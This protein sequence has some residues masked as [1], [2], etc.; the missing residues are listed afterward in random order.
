MSALAPIAIVGRGCV[1]PGALS[2]EE[3]WEGVVGGVDLT[4][5]VPEARWGVDVD[6]VLRSPGQ[7][8]TDGTWSDRGGYVTGFDEV[9]D[10]TGFG[11]D[12]A[13]I[14][15]LDPV[16]RWTLHTARAALRDAGYGEADAR[17]TGAVFGNLSYPTL[18]MAAHAS[19]VHLARSG[20]TPP[21]VDGA[22]GVRVDPRNRFMSG[23]PA[24]LLERALG[25]GVGAT[26][27]DAACAS[28][29]YAIE[30]AC[31]RLRSGEADLM[32]AGAV[33]AADDLFLHVGFTALRALS[34]TGRSRPFHP[35]ADGLVPA[36]GCGFVALRRLDDAVRDGDEIHGVVRGVGLSND[37][38]GRGMLA[39]SS[40]GQVRAIRSAL[41][42]SGLDP[43]D[44]SLLECHATGTTV[45]DATEVAS[46]A[47]AYGDVADLPIGSLKSN[48]GHLI[49]VA[50]VAAVIK[51]IEAMRHEVRPP[52]LHVGARPSTL[53]GS[54]F[55]VLAAAEAW[56]R[57]ESPDGV[58]RAGISAFGF[59]GNN[60]HLLLEEPPT[61]ARRPRRQGRG[62]PSPD[63]TD[64]AAASP[65][66]VGS[67]DDDGHE[68][69]AGAGRGAGPIAIV[70]IGV[71]AA[72]AVGLD[73]LRDALLAD[74]PRLDADGTGRIA[75]LELRL[76]AQRSPPNDLR[77]ALGQHLAVLQAA[78]EAVE[79]VELPAA[80]TGVVVGIGTDPV[81]T[82]FGTRW[83]LPTEVDGRSPTA[84]ERDAVAPALTAPGVLGAMPNLVANR[85]DSQYD[86]GG[87]SF[88]VSSEE[89]SGLDAL[90]IAV[91]ALRRGDLDAALVGAVDL[92]CDEVHL[93]AARDVLGDRGSA[94]P[95]GD[96][97]VVV[98]LKRL[99]DAERDGDVVHAVVT[100][101]TC[102]TPDG[103]GREPGEDVHLDPCDP[104]SSLGHLFGHAHA[105]AGLLHVAAAATMLRHRVGRGD[106]ALIARRPRAAR[107][108]D[109]EAGPRT[110][111]ITTTAMEGGVART[112][113]LA[114]AARHPAPGRAPT[115]G[116]HV[117]S[118][119]DVDEVLGALA[120]GRE[121]D[122]GPARL[123]IVAS[124]SDE[125]AE[126]ARRAESH[127]RDGA[128]AGIGVH[129]A[130]T[131]IEGELGFVFT[132]AGAAVGSMGVD[133]LRA[134]PE[135]V[136]PI[137]A[138]STI[139]AHGGWFV[140][141][142]ADHQPTA[143]EYLWGTAL[144]SQAHAR[145]SI[146]LLGLRPDA[147]LGSSSGESNSLYAMG[148]WSDLDAMIDEIERGGMLTHEIAGDF[149]AV[150]RAWGVED[151]DWQVWSVAAPVDEVRALV[152]GHERVHLMII[153]TEREVVIGGDAAGC[154]HVVDDVGRHRCRRVGYELACHVPEVAAAFHDEWRR[155]HDRPV[156]P[157]DGV[158]F[159]SNGV[160]GAYDVS[161]E[162]CADAITRQAETTVD[163][164][165]T[166]R[167]AY[168]DG[169]RVFVEHGPGGA[170]THHV[171][172]VLADEVAAGEVLAV[173]LDRRGAG[174][175][176]LLDTC[177][178]LAAAGVEVDHRALVDRIGRREPS[179]V[180]PDG[181]VLRIP[182]HPRPVVVP[183][184]PGPATVD[185]GSRAPGPT[186]P[187]A[188]RLPSVL[189]PLEDHLV[190]ATLE[191][192][193]P[194]A[195]SPAPPRVATPLATPSVHGERPDVGANAG[196]SAAAVAGPTDGP[197]TGRTVADLV[198]AQLDALDR[199]HRGYLAQQSELHER[200]LATRAA[201]LAT[202]EGSSA[203]THLPAAAPTTTATTAPARATVAPAADPAVATATPGAVQAPAVTSTGV[204]PGPLPGRTPTTAAAAGTPDPGPPTGGASAAGQ[205]PFRPPWDHAQLEIH[206]S[207]R[208]SE[209]FGPMFEPQD[210]HVVQCRMPRPPLL[211]ADRVTGIDAEPGVLGTGT[212]WT[213]TDVPADAWYLHAGRMPT[214]F[215]IEAGQ[216]DLML[217]SWM[218][219]DLL[220]RGRRA[221]RLLGCTLTYHGDLPRPGET[222]EYEIRIT[223][224][225][226]HGEVRLFFFEYDCTVAGVRRLTVRDGQAGFFTRAELEDA[227]GTVW[228]PEAGRAALRD[229][230]RVD[231][232]AVRCAKTR[233]DA[234]E[235][236]AFSEG[237]V[238]D[239]FGPGFE[240]AATHTRTPGIQSGALLFVDEVTDL[241]PTGGPWGRGFMRCE[242]AIAADAW[243]FEGH[244]KDDPCMPGNFMVESCVQ[245]MSFYLAAL[246]HTLGRDGWR[247]RP[248]PEQPF[249]LKCRGEI[250]PR[251]ERVAY[252]LHV[253]EVHDGP[254][255]R[256]VCDVLG[257]VDGSP[258]FHA[259]RL[260]IELV[261]GWPLE[262]VPVASASAPVTARPSLRDADGFAF[263]ER[264]MLACAWGRPTDAFGGL[265][266]DVDE[267]RRI[268]RLPGP[269]YH[270]VSRAVELDGET[271]EPRIGTRAVCEYDVPTDAWYFDD[272]S[273]G[274]EATMPFAVLLEVA[275]Q[276]C[277]WLASLVGSIVGVEGD[278]L[279][280]NL[281]GTATV[282][283]TVT[284]TAGRIATTV[285]L[286]RSSR[287]GG[288]IVE[289]FDVEC[290]VGDRVVFTTGTVFGFFPTSA[291]VDQAGLAVGDADRAA[292]RLDACDEVIDLADRP[293]RYF[294]GSAR[295]TS[296]PLLMLDRI[297]HRRGAGEAG[298]G[299]V[300]GERDVDGSDWSF[301][302]HFF[303]DPVQPGS[304]GMEALL[305]LLRCH[306]L[307]SVAADDLAGAVFEPIL[308]AT[309]TTW[310][311][312]GQ[313]TPMAGVITTT[314]EITASGVDE[315][316]PWAVGTGSLWCD[317]VRIYE[318][319]DLGSR[320]VAPTEADTP[321]GL[322]ELPIAVDLDL[323]PELIDHAVDGVPVVPVAL[324]LEWFTSLAT[325]RRRDLHLDALVELRVLAGVVLDGFSS[326]RRRELV[327]RVVGE[328]SPD[329]RDDVSDG[330]A[331]GCELELV[332]VDPSSGRAHY[333]CRARMTPDPAPL[334][335]RTAGVVG[336]TG[337]TQERV[338][339]IYD[340]DVLFHGPAFRVIEE[341]TAVRA[342]GL[343]ATCWGVTSVAWPDRDRLTDPALVDGALQLAVLWARRRLGAAALPTSIGVAR[344]SS[345]P[346][347]GRHTVAVTG[348]EESTHRAVCDVVVRSAE[349]EVVAVL[350]RVETHVRSGGSQRRGTTPVDP[351]APPDRARPFRSS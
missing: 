135:L 226:R 70:G 92:S 75:E 344:L 297:G 152:D 318:V 232:P 159:Y 274:G 172:E 190:D 237:R 319:S 112:V 228:T 194:P 272:P 179:S 213:E 286:T 343:E 132:A 48:T 284:P 196:G 151:V 102:G 323:H 270:F 72:G 287:A 142:G 67:P 315:R 136:T 122:G 186:M 107:G 336:P 56:P 45:G 201:S 23:L 59:G 149:R 238:V 304:L 326:G 269:P 253:E 328:R 345:P 110:A 240:A 181:P 96:A 15:G 18:G 87:R 288:M 95:P 13:E 291:F 263:D 119:S 53:D 12:P 16:F 130:R 5:R 214:G 105:A 183:A 246:G 167:A 325:R 155:V 55:R 227:L 153:D 258:S 251:T 7:D 120:D 3:L 121:S 293:A 77:A 235:V 73:A 282:H 50:G 349:G 52:S 245:A 225:A 244:F 347:R 116:L 76:A 54:P 141:A 156:T 118:G 1:L 139:G 163:L 74:A 100:S 113:V 137:T 330:G 97:A 273:D 123:V 65:G 234:R 14:D 38:R 182:A 165:A 220:N 148:V 84:E 223:G 305:Q 40:D 268:P 154:A 271:G 160:G 337:P 150:A 94:S 177:A 341:I 348:V 30:A 331:G 231:P 294:A 252:E 230:A 292:R 302:A 83:R 307:D 129:W 249:E 301:A 93:D 197:P 171:R 187:P 209:L 320:L 254:H 202:I 216:A 210:E 143:S 290:S 79:G 351:S 205:R 168:D 176:H 206:S 133:L 144:L 188:P 34:P 104:D 22:T 310:T 218:G 68:V 21:D 221:Y 259:H 300:V 4:S 267:A 207:G 184:A 174:L 299:V 241:D 86:L 262:T 303:Q 58:L 204:P 211:L 90:R 276:P 338:G 280:R 335:D 278:L 342:D 127:V 195:A 128:P 20:A 334:L 306:Q 71:V 260:G 170:C 11:L 131:P 29:L 17:R 161:S 157:V 125:L 64:V 158:R 146:D 26:A 57:T 185:V 275:L 81:A 217:I 256:V 247:F 175:E 166:I 332:L 191:A 289:G 255:P 19:A 236:R 200:F 62:A 9:F 33:N 51:V 145:L 2:P 109:D 49:T 140:G 41:E 308:P 224:H 103:T 248:L 265:Y 117:F 296:G 180:D 266:A 35:D 316:G 314:I 313:V 346:R 28:S 317:D 198:G 43:H 169:V 298:L 327:A 46:S 215:T 78:D 199:L 281:D 173:S 285:T 91:S 124:D 25:L 229:D 219:I 333:R 279:F 111:S 324:V 192:T 242:S 295:L 126:R 60:A 36:E 257:F 312:R 69:E 208:I 24:L 42:V 203:P 222:L 250:N 39:P 98:V 37:G 339:V 61:P 80:T 32:L 233:F 47:R 10:P 44:V 309:P 350:E 178:A 101:A 82:R 114:E 115:A 189:A 66:V 261:P 193:A 239:C 340:G 212:I 63:P 138:E 162:A 329:A 31:E 321:A 243:Y 322:A 264:A 85:L 277:G 311:Y 164:P 8:A 6:S 89:H 108:L 88:T 27:L 134:I 147:V 99:A 283:G 106:V